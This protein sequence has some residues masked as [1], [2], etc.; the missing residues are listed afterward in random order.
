[1]EIPIPTMNQDNKS[2]ISL[3]TVSKKPH[4]NKYMLVR[5]S[6]VKELVDNREIQIEYVKSENMV[7]DILTKPLQGSL[8][9]SLKEFILNH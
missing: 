4:R 9:V 6:V 8:F 5:Q 2:T 1:M 7:A 3:I